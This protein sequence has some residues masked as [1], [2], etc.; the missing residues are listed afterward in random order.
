MSTPSD[1]LGIAVVGMVGRFPGAGNLEEF[2]RN[3]CEGKESVR[4]L[5]DQEL[6]DRGLDPAL[7]K[8]PRHVRAVAEMEDPDSFDAEFF[9]ISHREAEILDPQQRVFLECAWQALES[10]GYHPE[11]CGGRV[12][13]F[14]GSTTST[15]LLFHLIADAAFEQSWDP[16]E[17]LVANAGD[18]LTTRASYRLNLKGPSFAV[19][20]AC[21]TSLV[22]VHLACESLLGEE[23]DMALAGG[24]SINVRQRTGYRYNE[25]SIVSPD[26]HCR[27]FDAGAQGTIFGSGVG[28]VVLKRLVDALEDG[29]TIHAVIR[30]SAVNNDGAMK[31]GPAA[32]GV[33]G[34]T[35]VIAEA[36]SVA[37]VP[38]E[39]ISYIE[40]HGSATNLGDPIEIQA[41]TRA[42]RAYTEKLG[43]C[44]LGS[45]KGNVGHLDVAAGVTGLIKTIL[46]LKHRQI[47]PSIHFDESNPKIDFARS[48]VFVNRRLL[49]W[50]STGVPRR[51]GVSSFG[52]GGTNAHTIVEEAP[53]QSESGRSRPWQL[54]VLSA[55]TPD[56]L[57]EAT[58]KLADHLHRN[59]ELHPADVA[60]TLSIG[61]KAFDHRRILVC[62]DTPDAAAKLGSPSSGH[63]LTRA[64]TLEPR[65]R[66]VVFILPGQDAPYLNLGRELYEVEPSFRKAVDRCADRLDPL[67]GCDLRQVL[68]PSPDEAEERAGMSEAA[69]FAAALF[70]VEY[71]LAR[72]WIEWGIEPQ[73]MIGYGIGEYVAAAV[74]GVF[75]LADA[76]AL[77]AAYA[78]RDEATPDAAM[79]SPSQLHRPQIPFFSN[80]T[81][82]WVSDQEAVDPG[83]WARPAPSTGHSTAALAQLACDPQQIL[84]ELGPGEMLAALA[85]EPSD[86]RDA[87][88]SMRSPEDAASSDVAVLLTALG[89]LWLAGREIEWPRF[90]A[91]QS[92]RRVSLPTYPFAR[93]SYWIEP[94]ERT[95]PP[96]GVV[97]GGPVKEPEI[98]DWFYLPCWRPSLPPRP[99]RSQDFSDRRERWLVFVDDGGLGADL[100]G[101]LRAAAQEVFE[102]RAGE[103]YARQGENSFVVDPRRPEDYDQLLTALGGAV[104]TILHLWNVSRL[105]GPRLRAETFARAQELG[106]Y[107]LLYL[108]KALGRQ[109]L[110][111]DLLL[112]VAANHLHDVTGEE[113]AFPE[114]ATLIGPC[115]GLSQ[116]SPRIT[117]RVVDV[118][119]PETGVVRPREQL[120]AECRMQSSDLIVAYRGR[121]RWVQ[122]F[123]KVRIE[124]KATAR[125]QLRRRGVYLITDGLGEVGLELAELLARSA[126]ARLVLVDRTVL[127]ERSEWE[128]FLQTHGDD[129]ETGRTIRRLQAMENAGAELLVITADVTDHR[130]M[131]LALRQLIKRF[132]TLHGI[133][134]ASGALGGESIY[135]PLAELD[136][137]ESE[138]RFRAAHGLYV[139]EKVIAERQP[140]FVLLFASTASVLGGLGLAAWAAADRFMDAFAARKAQAAGDEPAWIS[141]SWD[142]WRPGPE[143]DAV[144]IET[145]TDV[146][147][148][149]AEERREAFR[150]I[151]TRAPEGHIVISTGD[152]FARLNLWIDQAPVGEE[153]RRALY[154]RPQLKTEYVE[155]RND[156][157]RQIAA[158]WQ[159]LLGVRRVGVNDTFFELGGHSLLATQLVARFRESFQVS[160]PLDALFE[161]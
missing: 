130:E 117:C 145:S 50:R 44:A 58:A 89:R 96:A 102:V 30:G 61:R 128:S 18:F 23:C 29:D 136:R 132:G 137:T 94:Q 133:I 67:L 140:D 22:A 158:I 156:L 83:Y 147:A 138:E 2:W 139:L 5:S 28:I 142:R 43:F 48:P 72:L 152:L 106:Y 80:R 25:E 24:I 63:L 15:Y 9:G 105:K 45:V 12:G 100:V 47:P 54:L 99:I 6:L 150:R 49:E 21:S 69:L 121:R 81:E 87:F 10:A 84:L 56:A 98:A 75:S 114:K 154:D 111:E 78:R 59:P 33:E 74:A 57:D 14:A 71:A 119:V 110:E 85:Q 91:G 115:M 135:H 122:S 77:V 125:R 53:A 70:A 82:S 64:D 35:E 129:E 36:L 143:Q 65:P 40:A 39:S 86:E 127:P 161:N 19:Q 27:P 52:F 103:T 151:L 20:C 11:S 3:L 113:E 124:G 126:R 51:A 41:L 37:G 34:Q 32:L 92:R 16:L 68:Y 123:E 7:L 31:V 118:L 88:A 149:T 73:A 112:M 109:T 4:F 116:E 134:Y 148:M 93:H 42:F 60:Y 155:S 146:F 141:S 26:G 159:V 157:E 55:K 13:V 46:A 1:A 144:A 108:A 66:P 107:S 90:F 62:R 97:R 104:D 101:R 79:P 120:L 131:L 8:D 17:L 38:A 153:R 95:E 76:L 160:L